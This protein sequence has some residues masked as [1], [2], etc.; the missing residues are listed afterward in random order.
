M[1]ALMASAVARVMGRVS[2]C[3]IRMFQKSADWCVVQAETFRIFSYVP[4]K[5]KRIG[6]WVYEWKFFPISRVVCF[7]FDAVTVSDGISER[8]IL[9]CLKCDFYCLRT[10][11]ES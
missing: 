11:A 9:F 2:H 7:L 10:T 8:G 6:K 4:F 1:F 5:K 3:F